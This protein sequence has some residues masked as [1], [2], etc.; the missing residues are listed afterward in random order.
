[1]TFLQAYPANTRMPA[2]SVWGDWLGTGHRSF[3]QAREFAR[4]LKLTSYVEWKKYCKG[5][6]PGRGPKPDDIPASP[7]RCYKNDGWI[8]GG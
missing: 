8:S 7:H 1:M 4:S 2:G 5:E 3:K 6:L